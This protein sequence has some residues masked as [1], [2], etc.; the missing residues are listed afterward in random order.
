VDAAA[1]VAILRELVRR[2]VLTHGELVDTAAFVRLARERG[3]AE[4]ETGLYL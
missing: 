4:P 2:G 3:H 1:R